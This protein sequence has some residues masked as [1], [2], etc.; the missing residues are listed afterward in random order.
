M[1]INAVSDDPT[2]GTADPAQL[3]FTATNWSAAQTVTVTGVDDDIADGN[4]SYHVDLTIDAATTASNYA[5]LTIS[6]VALT[7]EED[8]DAVGIT[9]SETSVTTTEAAGEGNTATF[10]V[11]LNSEPTADVTV[12]VASTNTDEAT[13]SAASLTFTALN[14]DTPQEITVTGVDDD[15]QDGNQSYTIQLGAAVSDDASYSGVD[16][17]DVAGSNTDDDTAGITV[18][19]TTITTTE[20]AGDSHTA[21]DSEPAAEITVSVMSN[22]EA[23]ATVS[24]ATLTF[25]SGN[26]STAQD[27]TVTGVTAGLTTVT[28]D[29]SGDSPYNLLASTDVAVTV[30]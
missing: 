22:S 25:T 24:P 16:P 14:W 23:T 10:T 19:A 26:W 20:A 11:V 27:V 21:L 28:L 30:N 7:N 6:P 12:S 18:S 17:A 2:E 9:V 13:V 4:V 8:S 1:I 29:P 3:T 5:A 15:V